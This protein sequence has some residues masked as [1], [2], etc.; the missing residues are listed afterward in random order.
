MD[1]IEA[2]IHAIDLTLS[3]L[4]PPD[5]TDVGNGLN[6]IAEQLARK[7]D[8]EEETLELTPIHNAIRAH[9]AER[10][11]GHYQRS[12][13]FVAVRATT[14][15]DDDTH[16]DADRE[17]FFLH[18]TQYA[19]L[20]ETHRLELAH[21]FANCGNNYLRENR[22]MCIVD[23]RTEP[24]ANEIQLEFVVKTFGPAGFSFGPHECAAAA[25]YVASERHQ[26]PCGEG[27]SRNCGKCKSRIACY[28]HDWL[29][30]NQTDKEVCDECKDD[31]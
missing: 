22:W 18:R 21:W 6:K 19:L 8:R 3:N 11:E 27:S 1:G 15:T 30:R 24:M 16:F 20:R 7:R 14:F 13:N 12:F 17:C 29:V 25:M 4:C 31:E 2:A 26:T 9:L 10:T 28:A 5:M 23:V